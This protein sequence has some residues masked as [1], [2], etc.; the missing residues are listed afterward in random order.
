MCAILKAISNA[1][2]ADPGAAKYAIPTIPKTSQ[3]QVDRHVV[4]CKE[5]GYLEVEMS[6]A[7]PIYIRR[8]TFRGFEALEHICQGKH[9]K[10]YS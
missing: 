4:L 2:N 7:G 9:E 3:A 5:A 8:M 1:E 10:L 6:A